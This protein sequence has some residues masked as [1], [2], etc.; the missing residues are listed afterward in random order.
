MVKF[1]EISKIEI[2]SKNIFYL[3]GD[4]G[5]LRSWQDELTLGFY[6]FFD[7]LFF[8]ENSDLSSFKDLADPTFRSYIFFWSIESFQILKLKPNWALIFEQLRKKN[9]IQNN[10]G[11]SMRLDSILKKH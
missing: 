10:I 7:F 4:N 9:N 2:L 8:T 3:S 5:R 11:L 1:E 6:D